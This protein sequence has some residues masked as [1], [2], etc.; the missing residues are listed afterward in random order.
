MIASIALLAVSVAAAEYS[1]PRT[2]NVDKKEFVCMMQD[3]VMLRKGI[4]LTSGGKKYWGCC[5]MCKVKIEAEPERYTKAVDLV[6]GK[7]VDKATAHI[8]A[9]EGLVY[10][11]ESKRTRSA[12]AASPSRYLQQ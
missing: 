9:L 10:Y 6:S 5:E 3:M 2:G 11:F 1:P 4:P 7:R 8:Y 12:F